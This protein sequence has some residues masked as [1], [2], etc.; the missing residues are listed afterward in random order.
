[1][2]KRKKTPLRFNE[3]V[4]DKYDSH[5]RNGL[6][7][8]T[9]YDK[10][11]YV[12]KNIA[13]NINPIYQMFGDLGGAPVNGWPD[14]KMLTDIFIIS[15]EDYNSLKSGEVSEDVAYIQKLINNQQTLFDQDNSLLSS[16]IKI[17]KFSTFNK[18]SEERKARTF[19]PKKTSD[20]PDFR[21]DIYN[22][23]SKG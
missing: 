16:K 6:E 10:R 9:F 22:L 5:F 12:S 8:N 19:I 20:E 4:I 13:S 17:V 14:E 7:V 18:Y 15:D 3:K 11:V 21:K 23:Y 1:M 2:A